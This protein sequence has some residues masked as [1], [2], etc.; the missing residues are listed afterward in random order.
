MPL[1]EH[2][3]KLLQ[4]MEQALYAEDPHFANRLENTG[5]RAGRRR[6]V[7]GLL[8]VIVGL[9]VIVL[10]VMNAVIVLGGVGFLIMVAGAFYALTPPRHPKQGPG[11]A[12]PGGSKGG[13]RPAK[14]SRA[15]PGLMQRLE[16]RWD[17]R[18][19]DR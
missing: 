3:Q 4:Q 7:I 11:S 18:R 16:Q 17:D 6:L 12:V 15:K 14:K 2:E 19:S 10:A 8:A 13:G 5:S 1:S 9:V